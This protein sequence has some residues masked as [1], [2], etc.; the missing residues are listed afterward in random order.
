MDGTIK[1]DFT[2]TAGAV[3]PLHG[4]NN[5]PLRISEGTRQ[6]EFKKAG[7]PFLRV[8]ACAP[9]DE[10]IL[11]EYGTVLALADYALDNAPVEAAGPVGSLNGL[12]PR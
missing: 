1:S 4:V 6:D 3:K 11:P 10:R 8:G 9:G 5:A 7:I 2:K 12:A